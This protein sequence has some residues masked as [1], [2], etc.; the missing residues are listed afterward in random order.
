MTVAVL[1]PGVTIADARRT[2]AQSFRRQ[3]V[4]SA[5]LDARILIGH[6][7][8]LDHAHLVATSRTIDANDVNA[9]AQ[10]AARRLA[11]EPVARIIG[12]KE[13]WGLPL[14]LSAA[15][16]VPRPE[17]ET[18]VEA[19][20]AA[21]DQD[22]GRSRPLR[23]ADLGTGTGALLLAL[24]MEL[25]FAK[26][27]AT[28]VAHEAIVTARDNARRFGLNGRTYFTVCDF[29]TALAG[30]FD[31]VVSN[32]P[33]IAHADIA[34]LAPEVRNH[35]PLLALDGGEDGLTSYRFIAADA[36]R[37]LTPRG[38]LVLELGVGQ[39]QAVCDLLL[40]A[41]LWPQNPAC[42]DL[43]GIPRALVARP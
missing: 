6:A 31:L 32:P 33:Y 24:L 27:V 29:G 10:L 38:V 19:A 16:L 1:T 13:F 23:I 2:L 17:T 14:S 22:G 4:E 39:A 11:R 18:V 21:I 34:A 37:L 15:T 42:P 8:C 20:L 5:E 28:D 41:G 9:I 36:R 25:P 30:G 3:G 12:T 43:A 40:G 7:L 26:G 35:D